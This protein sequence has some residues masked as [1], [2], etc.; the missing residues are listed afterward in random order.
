[1]GGALP[2]LHRRH[3][4]LPPAF[5]AVRFTGLD[6]LRFGRTGAIP[7][8]SDHLL[9]FLPRRSTAEGGRVDRGFRRRWRREDLEHGGV[10]EGDSV[11]AALP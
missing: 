9:R 7:A 4:P 6:A 3:H 1:M 8:G 11:H 2:P 5:H 10:S